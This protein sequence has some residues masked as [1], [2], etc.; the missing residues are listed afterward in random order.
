MF[1]LTRGQEPYEDEHLGP[2]IITR[3]ASQE[4]PPLGESHLDQIVHRCWFNKYE[5]LKALAEDAATLDGVL[6]VPPPKALGMNEFGMLKPA[7][8]EIL[9]VI[10]KS[11]EESRQKDA[12]K[13]E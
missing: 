3:F 9:G 6:T 11:V 7:C 13:H 1:T 5:S 2:G 12:A 8:L 4:F 10:N